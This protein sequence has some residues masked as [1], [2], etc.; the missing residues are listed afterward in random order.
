MVLFVAIRYMKKIPWGGL[1]GIHVVMFELHSWLTVSL[2]NLFGIVSLNALNLTYANTNTHN[3]PSPFL[4]FSLL[5]LLFFLFFY[6]WDGVCVWHYEF[7]CF[8]GA[9]HEVWFQCSYVDSKSIHY[10][11]SRFL[12]LNYYGPIVPTNPSWKTTD[13]KLCNIM[14][15]A[16]L[17]KMSD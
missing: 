13:H 6:F 12:N 10:A 11:E 3:Y 17:A 14:F 2:F 5:L 7:L 1:S 9:W 15:N 16:P 8:T 4:F